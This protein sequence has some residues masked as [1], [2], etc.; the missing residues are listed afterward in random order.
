MSFEGMPFGIAALAFVVCVVMAVLFFL[1]Y[2]K[3]KKILFII[4]GVISILLSIAALV[5][6]AL[7]LIL[8]AAV[9]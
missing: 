8:L 9:K 6:C 4:L 2:R 5:Y 3:N 7:T 1:L